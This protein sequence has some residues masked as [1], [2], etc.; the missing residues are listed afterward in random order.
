M[1]A[2]LTDRVRA[3]GRRS[4][5]VLPSIALFAVLGVCQAAL[6]P[7][8]P[9]FRDEFGLPAPTVGLLVSAFFAGALTSTLIC[10]ALSARLVGPHLITLLLALTSAGLL[11]LAHL[12]AW[13]GRLAAGAALGL[14]FGGL[15]LLVNTYM[16]GHGGRRGATLANVVNG[17]F[18]FGAAIGPGILS[19]TLT[20]GYAYSLSVLAIVLVLLA[21]TPVR[22]IAA[23]PAAPATPTTPLRP[24]TTTPTKTSIR[25]IGAFC[26]LL[27]CY[28]GL[29]TGLSTWEATHL[30]AVGYSPRVATAMTSLFWFG[31]AG[32]RL[33]APLVTARRPA[34]RVIVVALGGSLGPL[35]L[36]AVPPAAPAGYL[37]AGVLA[38]PVLPSTLAWIAGTV[39][40]PRRA[41]A[42]AV[43]SAMLGS[44]ALPAAIGVA[45]DGRSPEALPL[46]VA[47]SVMLSLIAARLARR[48]TSPP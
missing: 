45:V 48:L 46:V 37:L 12:P 28:A 3:P 39:P 19:L 1:P 44:I 13:P 30:R 26:A 25:T 11:G 40:D 43:A 15:T 36:I 14:G 23:A 6:G 9:I 5:P 31:L 21:Q 35:A 4:S 33:L 34:H 41:N 38:G 20:A 32:G 8:M 17:V 18:G 24:A 7:L 22:R 42:L 2:P 27:F 10:G 16:A 29:E 47:V